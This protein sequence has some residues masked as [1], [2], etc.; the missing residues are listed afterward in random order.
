M[1][2]KLS[3]TFLVAFAAPIAAAPASAAAPKLLVVISV[4]QLSSDLYDE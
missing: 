2:G 3:F 4:D 1:F